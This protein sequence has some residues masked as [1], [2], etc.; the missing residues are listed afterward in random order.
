VA[1]SWTVLEYFGAA[2]VARRGDYAEFR[3]HRHVDVLGN[4]VGTDSPLSFLATF[5]EHRLLCSVRMPRFQRVC[6]IE[7]S[8]RK[9]GAMK[10]ASA[11]GQTS[12]KLVTALIN[13][14][15]KAGLVPGLIRN[16]GILG[17]H[18]SRKICN[19]RRARFEPGQA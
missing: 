15:C 2:R 12:S 11:Y 13:D 18:S 16:C 3:E 7:I 17:N 5:G 14:T 1:A 6:G 9:N 19:S 8:R 10:I 4:A